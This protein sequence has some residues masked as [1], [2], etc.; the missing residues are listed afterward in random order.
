MSCYVKNILLENNG[1]KKVY[2]V[3]INNNENPT[4]QAKWNNLFQNVDW[5]KIYGLVFRITRDTYIQWFQTRIIHRI[6]ATNSLLFKMKIVNDI[7][8]TF[9]LSE[10]ETL[11][12]L[13]WNC[14]VVQTLLNCVKNVI[15]TGNEPF[16]LDCQTFML[17]STCEN[18]DKYNILY[19][20]IKKYIYLCKRKKINPSF[21]GLKGSLKLSWN[22]YKNT[23]IKDNEHTN[24]SVVRMF[25]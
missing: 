3:L 14:N 11:V 25:T 1:S 18:C 9:C 19:Y 13:F 8:C 22:I 12:H 21:V 7:L 5:K 24:W 6:L 17:G 4:C 15:S 20:E 16:T 10:E 23:C 2:N